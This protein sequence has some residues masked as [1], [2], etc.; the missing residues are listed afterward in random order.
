MA[1]YNTEHFFPS[2][3]LKVGDVEEYAVY[4]I[5]SVESV[6]FTDQD[7][8]EERPKPV[9]HFNEI[10]KGL[11]MN[12]GAWQVLVELYSTDPSMVD[13]DEWIGKKVQVHTP[14]ETVFGKRQRVL[15]LQKPPAGVEPKPKPKAGDMAAA[16]KAWSAFVA[17]T[18]QALDHVQAA[19]GTSKPSEWLEQNPGKDIAD[20]I[21]RVRETMAGEEIPEEPEPDF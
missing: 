9:L 18:P 4:T 12:S 5:K 10:G 3:Y 21:A 13:T 14:Y 7:S 11:V 17:A 15:R 1:G 16:K 2:K 20:A 6:N 19:L 8:N